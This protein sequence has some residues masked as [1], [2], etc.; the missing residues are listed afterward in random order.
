MLMLGKALMLMLALAKILDV[1]VRA[2]VGRPQMLMKLI[3]D[4]SP[5]AAHLH[6]VSLHSRTRGGGKDSSMLIF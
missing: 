3:Y 5:C 1:I 2:R 4:V 6:H